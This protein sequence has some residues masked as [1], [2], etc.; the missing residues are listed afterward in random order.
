MLRIII[1]LFEIGPG[2]HKR[3]VGIG[4]TASAHSRNWC[5]NRPQ[6]LGL[7]MWKDLLANLSHHRELRQRPLVDIADLDV[8]LGLVLR[9]L[10]IVADGQQR[11][12]NVIELANVGRD[13]LAD[14]QSF[15]ERSSFR[16]AH[17]DFELA[18]IVEREEVEPDARAKHERRR[19]SQQ[20]DYADSQ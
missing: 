7:E 1:K 11:V 4:S 18:L 13:P 9:A 17:G 14:V 20:R 5:D 3:N 2:Q 12:A 6:I 16:R 15:L 8:D 10:L 19:K